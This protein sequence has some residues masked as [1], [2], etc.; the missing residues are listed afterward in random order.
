MNDKLTYHSPCTTLCVLATKP[1]CSRTPQL[2]SS[3][4]GHS[5]GR[6]AAVFALRLNVTNVFA[7]L[8]QFTILRSNK[9][10]ALYDSSFLLA[11]GQRARANGSFY[12]AFYQ[13]FTTLSR[14]G[15]VS[16]LE[17][18]IFSSRETCTPYDPYF[19]GYST[20]SYVK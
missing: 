8:P 5:S 16:L 15:R 6:L 3:S 14:Y 2:R 9:E 20:Y 10:R 13:L 17:G 4:P 7:L 18:K 12:Q 1:C 11:N 19:I